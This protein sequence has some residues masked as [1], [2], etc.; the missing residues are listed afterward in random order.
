MNKTYIIANDEEI[1]IYHKPLP[2][3]S[4]NKQF[5]VANLERLY[6]KKIVKK[7][8]GKNHVSYEVRVNT[9]TGADKQLV[10]F[11]NSEEALFIEQILEDYL[12]IED[13]P[14]EGEIGGPK[15]PNFFD[16]LNGL[17]D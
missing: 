11:S 2:F 3:P 16:R 17:H 1:I 12:N 7:N 15:S 10:V 13:E 14:R 9:Y 5:K 4:V 8:N 6:S